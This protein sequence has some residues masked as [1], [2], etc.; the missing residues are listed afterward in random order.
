METNAA[1]IRVMFRL[2]LRGQYLRIADNIGVYRLQICH[3]ES[4]RE[5]T[6]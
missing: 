5:G 4:K 1:F 2:V 3:I 6:F